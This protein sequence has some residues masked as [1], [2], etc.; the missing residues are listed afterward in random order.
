MRKAPFLLVILVIVQSQ[1][2]PLQS[3]ST[4]DLNV[5]K[6]LVNNFFGLCNFIF[7]HTADTVKVT[8]SFGSLAI[9]TVTRTITL[10]QT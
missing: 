5:I 10:V 7:A 6:N 9:G 3:Q 1:G 4:N 8:F 2:A